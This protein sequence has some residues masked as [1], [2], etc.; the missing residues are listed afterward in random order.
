LE[1]YD[2][3][4][5]FVYILLNATQRFGYAYFGI[6]KRL[7]FNLLLVLFIAKNHNVS[8]LPELC[9]AFVVF[10]CFF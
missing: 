6:L 3:R 7:I 2:K 9:I 1:G 4:I 8:T 10:S 5:I